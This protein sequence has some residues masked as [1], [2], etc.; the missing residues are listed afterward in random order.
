M[1][2]FDVQKFKEIYEREV[3]K[4]MRD[5]KVPGLSVL[6][7]KKGKTIYERNFGSREWTGTKPTTSD[8]LYGIAS[9]TKSMTSTAIL[10]LQEQGKLDIKD[11][12]SKYIPVS[13]GIENIP[14]RVEDLMCHGSGLPNLASYS[15]VIKNEELTP[16]NIPNL[17]MGNWDD[18]YFHVNDAQDWLFV[19]PRE[20]FY[21]N[22][23]GYTMLSQIIAK[24]SG[25][26]YEEFMEKQLFQP[27]GMNRSTFDR[28][29]LEKDSDVSKGYSTEPDE[30]GLKRKP[31]PH[32]SSIFNSGA[33]GLNSSTREM[34]KYIQF[35]LNQGRVNGK[36]LIAQELIEEMHKAQNSIDKSENY[37][38][39]DETQNYG[40]GFGIIENFHGVKVIIHGGASGVSGGVVLFIPELE[41]TYTHLYN[42]GWLSG[43]IT[44]MALL[45]LIGKDPEDLPFLKRRKHFKKLQGSYMAYRKNM[46]VK[47]IQ[48]A[49][50]LY[51]ES[52]IIEKTSEPL[53]PVDPKDP[54]PT[55]F[56]SYNPF[57][58]QLIQFYDSD[59]DNIRFDYERNI[60]KKIDYK[61][62]LE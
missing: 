33:G 52:D 60:F 6:I 62:E 57:G 10:M 12:I 54:C 42:V 51:I 18:F 8:T 15:A 55:N 50:L 58:R 9:M 48:K 49:G 28:D 46:E 2:D 17:P 32:L 27:L 26:S 20:K 36:Q 41:I 34:T 4:L 59:N 14:I 40:Y 16:F 56:Y 1:A 38:V 13:I 5:S 3:V 47:V 19:K 30:K 53:I 31:K 39:V 45:A 44:Y 11:P 29:K 35:H 43:H 25:T 24:V 61:P 37:L 21:Y 7:T 22:N 23:D